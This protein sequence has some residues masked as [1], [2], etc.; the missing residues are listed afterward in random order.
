MLILCFGL[1]VFD[2]VCCVLNEMSFLIVVC[3]VLGCGCVGVVWVDVVIVMKVMK[4]MVCFEKMLLNC[5]LDVM[6]GRV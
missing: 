5:W 1:V 2:V 6:N 4:V 3:S